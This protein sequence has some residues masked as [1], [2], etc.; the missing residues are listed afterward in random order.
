M[1]LGAGMCR[2]KPDDALDLIR[3]DPDAGIDP[4]L[5]ETIQP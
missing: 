2:D 3:L 4:T 1:D 5:T